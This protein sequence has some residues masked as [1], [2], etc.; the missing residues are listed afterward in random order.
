MGE[1]YGERPSRSA[2]E[3]MG[4]WHP[5]WGWGS[6][7]KRPFS[8]LCLKSQLVESLPILSTHEWYD[9][10][11]RTVSL[12]I[13]A[14]CDRRAILILV[15]RIA[16]APLYSPLTLRIATVPTF[17]ISLG[18]LLF[19]RHLRIATSLP[20]APSPSPFPVVLLSSSS[21]ESHTL[22]ST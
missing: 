13:L 4:G 5:P 7:V 8:F 2:V 3:D 14:S 19:S 21:I 12:D 15:T 10:Y 9:E 22:H 6:V 16:T 20:R 17:S 18:R 11:L 1:S